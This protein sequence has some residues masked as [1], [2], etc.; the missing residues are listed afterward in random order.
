MVMTQE[1]IAII[2]AMLDSALNGTPIILNRED[3][4]FANK[5]M[6]A[7]AAGQVTYNEVKLKV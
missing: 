3:V 6:D 4:Y 7:L 2:E 5:F 1:Q